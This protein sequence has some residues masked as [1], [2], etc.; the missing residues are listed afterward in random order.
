MMSNL[1]LMCLYLYLCM[2]VTFMSYP[3]GQRMIE[4]FFGR[5]C[6]TVKVNRPDSQR[7]ILVWL[8]PRSIENNIQNSNEQLSVYDRH[9]LEVEFN[10]LSDLLSQPLSRSI[11]VY[12]RC[13]FSVV[14]VVA[15]HPR[16]R[17]SPNSLQRLGVVRVCHMP[18][19][20]HSC[21]H[22]S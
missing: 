9:L 4:N 7:E 11:Q 16:M 21:R 3:F 8:T 12:K 17:R 22:F 2:H 10:S 6:L 19:G 15:M 20:D 18:Y 1:I 14:V 13:R 5:V